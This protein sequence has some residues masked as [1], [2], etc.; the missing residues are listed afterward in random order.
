M[1]LLGNGSEVWC[2]IGWIMFLSLFVLKCCYFF[3]LFYISSWGSYGYKDYDYRFI[4]L[5]NLSC[6]LFWCYFL[7]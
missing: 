5:Y 2:I 4:Y 3:I 7:I 6:F 1:C